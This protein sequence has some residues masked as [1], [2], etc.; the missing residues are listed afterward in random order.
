MSKLRDTKRNCWKYI[1]WILFFVNEKILYESGW[2]YAEKENC[3]Y[4]ITG[5]SL[6]QVSSQTASNL[7]NINLS[8]K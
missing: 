1:S 6:G 2:N 8:T 7:M 3:K 4:L 5:E